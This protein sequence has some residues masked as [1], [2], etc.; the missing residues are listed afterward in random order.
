MCPERFHVNY[1]VEKVLVAGKYPAKLV[2]YEW[3]EDPRG[4]TLVCQFEFDGKVRKQVFFQS[5]FR[6]V[7]GALTNQLGWD[8]QVA[9]DGNQ[10]LD[11]VKE[12]DNLFV[13][14]N[15]DPKHGFNLSFH[16]DKIK[17]EPKLD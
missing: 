6:Y 3:R 11:A 15:Y 8:R 1:V 10:V 7:F 12:F 17:E 9:H 14:V 13:V 5:R 2:S 16:E 4:D